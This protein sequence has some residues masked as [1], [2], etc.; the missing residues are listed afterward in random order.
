MTTILNMYRGL[1]SYM[2]KLTSRLAISIRQISGDVDWAD[3]TLQGS[4]KNLG[5]G[6]SLPSE[7]NAAILKGWA[8]S[9]LMHFLITEFHALKS[10]NTWFRHYIHQV[11]VTPR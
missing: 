6:D 10:F 5:V 7:D 4:R 9:Y 11:W 2:L 1:H 8:L 3:T